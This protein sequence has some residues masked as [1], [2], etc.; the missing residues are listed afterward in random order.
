MSPGPGSRA[1][2]AVKPTERPDIFCEEAEPSFEVGQKRLSFD[3]GPKRGE[4]AEPSFK[5]GQMRTKKVERIEKLKKLEQSAKRLEVLM[6]EMKDEAS[7]RK[8]MFGGMMQTFASP[9]VMGDEYMM[10]PKGHGTSTKP[11]QK[12]LR[13]NCDAEVADRIC[14]FNRKAAEESG[15]FEETDFLEDLSKLGKEKQINFYDSNSGRVLFTAPK[16]R[17]LEQ[18]IEESKHHGWP[19]FRDQEVNWTNVRVLGD[20]EAISVHGTHLGHCFKD[21]GAGH[22]YCINIVSIAGHPAATGDGILVKGLK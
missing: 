21:P 20:G 15:Y 17:S 19:S 12:H 7:N 22:R 13:W 2:S 6:S 4:E 10:Q 9:V 18:F 1:L 14:N 16:G 5:S 8:S 11:V 3:V